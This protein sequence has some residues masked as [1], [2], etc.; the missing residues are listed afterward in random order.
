[1]CCTVSETGI[2]VYG[3]CICCWLLCT[4]ALGHVCAVGVFPGLMHFGLLF[5]TLLVPVAEVAKDIAIP[6]KFAFPGKERQDSVRSGLNVRTHPIMLLL[7][8]YTFS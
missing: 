2:Q 3:V 1:M 4:K 5:L 8:D 7:F 6:V